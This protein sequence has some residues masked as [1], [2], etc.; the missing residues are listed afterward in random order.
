MMTQ[1]KQITAL[2]IGVAPL[3]VRA[4]SCSCNLTGLFLMV[5]RL[6]IRVASMISSSWYRRGMKLRLLDMGTNRKIAVGVGIRN[7]LS[8]L[9]HAVARIVS[10]LLMHF[11]LLYIESGVFRFI[12]YLLFGFN[13]LFFLQ[14]SFCCESLPGASESTTSCSTEGHASGSSTEGEFFSCKESRDSSAS[15]SSVGSS[16]ESDSPASDDSMKVKDGSSDSNTEVSSGPESPETRPSAFSD[17]FYHLSDG[18]IEGL[19]KDQ[20]KNAYKEGLEKADPVGKYGEISDKELFQAVRFD[21]HDL[22][23]LEELSTLCKDLR[24]TWPSFQ[25]A[26]RTSIHYRLL[27]ILE[28]HERPGID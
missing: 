9:I 15:P 12:F 27:M 24:G 28:E 17:K 11:F 8:S 22:K 20:I 19:W 10:Y 7:A 26:E 18:E 2:F 13:L 3:I 23:S 21:R 4:R 6:G 16:K 1:V 14:I 25:D 5:S